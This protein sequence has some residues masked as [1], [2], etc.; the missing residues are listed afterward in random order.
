MNMSE[1]KEKAL[2]KAVRETAGV[3]LAECYQ[4]GKCTAGCPMARYMD[5]TPN[6]VMRLA[7]VGDEAALETLLGSE[8]LWYC[9]GCLTCAQ[10]CPRQLDPAAVMDVLR[11]MA[12]RQGKI[13]AQARKILAFHQAFLATVEWGGRMAEI[14]LVMRYKLASLDLLG[15]ALLA[16]V[17]LAKRKLPLKPHRIKGRGEVR[18]I[19]E[20]CRTG[21][22]DVRPAGLPEG[23]CGISDTAGK[24]ARS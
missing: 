2:T 7:Q 10:R 19:F 16:P 14:P 24:E 21:G 22:K 6:Q 11:E 3:V 20:K 4:C 17:M 23:R 12:H 5:L 18:R 15:D 9:A 13:P 1:T 8:A